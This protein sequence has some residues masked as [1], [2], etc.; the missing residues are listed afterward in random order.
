MFHP[1][2]LSFP[3][4]DSFLESQSN[5]DL[6]F[7]LDSIT[8]TFIWSLHLLIS[9]PSSMVFEHLQDL[10][11]LKDSTNGFPQLFQVL[12]YQMIKLLYKGKCLYVWILKRCITFH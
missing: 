8:S 10:F 7:S 11:D 12:L 4:L 1:L 5:S 9:G 6:E 2:Y 3:C